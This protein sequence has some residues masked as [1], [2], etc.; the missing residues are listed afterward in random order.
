MASLQEGVAA[1]RP[2]AHRREQAAGSGDVGALLEDSR[3]PEDV[4]RALELSV[5][6]GGGSLDVRSDDMVVDDVSLRR[7]VPRRGEAHC[8]TDEKR[9]RLAHFVSR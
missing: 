5:V 3:D 9:S 7:Q 4:G 1:G 2:P 6:R 8:G